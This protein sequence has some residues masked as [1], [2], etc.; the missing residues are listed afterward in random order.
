MVVLKKVA[1]IGG[2]GYGAIELIRLLHTHPKLKVTKVISHSQ[3]GEVLSSIYPHLNNIPE[4]KLEELDI[5]SLEKEV[6]LVFLATPA[7]VASEIVPKL[8]HT[9][10]QIIDLSG[11][12]R[13]ESRETY[14]AWYNKPAAPDE[15]IQQAVYG[16][17]EIYKEEIQS[18]T[19]I[20]NPGCFPTSA[21]LGLI[22]AVELGFIE[23]KGI[24]IDGKTGISGAGRTPSRATHLS[25]ANDNVAPY[26]IGSHQHIPEVEQYLSKTKKEE[27]TTILTTHLIPMTRGL[28]CT[29]YATL[30]ED[31]TTE[32]VIEAYETYYQDSPFVRILEKGQFPKTK[33]VQ[34]SNFCDIGIVANK[35]TNQL[36]ITAAIDNLV[37]GASGQAVQNANIMNGWEEHLGLEFIP[38]Y[39]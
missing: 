5:P 20:S 7:G 17:S 10:L 9:N 2:T 19:L 28:I 13:L 33:A 27:V 23:S 21:L 4:I 1:I 35:R 15:T 6:D 24:I 16:L 31:K 32:E 11:D 38:M 12:L 30:T 37:K 18:A 3:S 39:P 34:G 22:P 8:T 36:I 14:E 25:E 26:K 29:M